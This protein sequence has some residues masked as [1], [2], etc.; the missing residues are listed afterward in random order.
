[1]PDRTQNQ[2][3]KRKKTRL[4]ILIPVVLGMVAAVATLTFAAPDVWKIFQIPDPRYDTFGATTPDH[5]ITWFSAETDGNDLKITIVFSDTIAVPN[6]DPNYAVLG[7][8][9]LD[10]DQ[11]QASG[12]PS[13]LKPITQCQIAIKGIEYF[14]DLSTY[15][16]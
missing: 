7:F 5:D 14:V 8:I 15:D 3:W 4:L 13:H 12:V 10:T 9:D 6:G 11:N 16:S 2:L 1:M